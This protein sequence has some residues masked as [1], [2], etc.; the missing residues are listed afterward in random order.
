MFLFCFNYLIS[1]HRMT[2]KQYHRVEDIHGFM[3]YLAKTYPSIVSVN[4]IGKS[5]EGRDIKVNQLFKY[6]SNN[7]KLL[8]S[9][10]NVYKN[11]PLFTLLL[12]WRNINHTNSRY[13]SIIQYVLYRIR[14]YPR[15]NEFAILKLAIDISNWEVAEHS[16]RLS[17]KNPNVSCPSYLCI[18]SKYHHFNV[19]VSNLSI[20]K[21]PE[22]NNL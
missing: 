3:D 14:P 16:K 7:F 21:F 6:I 13:C 15:R 1:G 12:A 11:L 20:R 22:P 18:L 17:K 4:T 9:Q 5:Y 8:L 2:W 19:W 10:S